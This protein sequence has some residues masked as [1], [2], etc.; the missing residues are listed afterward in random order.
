MQQYA[1]DQ[2]AKIESSRMQWVKNNQKTIRAEKYQG[3][4]DAV[5]DGELVNVGRKVIL[6]PT[7]H[8][9]PR[10]YSEAFMDAMTIVRK[11]GMSDYFITFTTKPK[12]PEIQEFLFAGET[13]QDRPDLACRVFKLKYDSNG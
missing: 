7:I 10:F 12:W 3:L 11:F 8:G 2:W 4:F 6:P 13:V 5:I 1:V 9:S